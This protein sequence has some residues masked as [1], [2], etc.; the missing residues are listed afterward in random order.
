M[1]TSVYA[2]SYLCTRVVSIGLAIRF[3]DARFHAGYVMRYPRSRTPFM[4]M[5]G[6]HGVAAS[7]Q[8]TMDF[9]L[10][11]GVKRRVD[12]SKGFFPSPDS[13]NSFHIVASND[14]EVPD[15]LG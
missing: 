4:D 5:V 15:V 8:G 1:G 9:C 11:E 14:D 10:R 6:I 12:A 7:I 2:H 3:R 13:F